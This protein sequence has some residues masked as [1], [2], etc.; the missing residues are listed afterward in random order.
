MSLPRDEQGRQAIE[1]PTLAACRW[2]VARIEGFFDWESDRRRPA[3]PEYVRD[4]LREVR[5]EL[6]RVLTPAEED[7]ACSA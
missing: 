3:D 1:N 6:A 5:D 4:V 7:T 2:A